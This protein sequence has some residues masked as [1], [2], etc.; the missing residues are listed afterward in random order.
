M[1]QI[2]ELEEGGDVSENVKKPEGPKTKERKISQAGF[3]HTPKRVEDM[4]V[5][6]KTLKELVDHMDRYVE[7][8]VVASGSKDEVLEEFADVLFVENPTNMDP[9][10]QLLVYHAARVAILGLGVAW[11]EGKSE[12]IDI[13][14]IENEKKQDKGAKKQVKKKNN[15]E[16]KLPKN[17]KKQVAKKKKNQEKKE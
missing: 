5:Q 4:E 10:Q 8:M 2:K 7:K 16:N 6:L 9:K 11:N 14:E 12:K 17:E 15:T 1:A 13:Q 3:K